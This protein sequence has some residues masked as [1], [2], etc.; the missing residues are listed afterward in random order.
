MPHC[1][2]LIL[3]SAYVFIKSLQV[4]MH[5]MLLIWCI[6]SIFQSEDKKFYVVLEK[7]SLLTFPF[8][9]LKLNRLKEC[10]VCVVFF[11]RK[12][13]CE[14]SMQMACNCISCIVTIW[15]SLLFHSNALRFNHPRL[16]FAG[17][18]CVYSGL[19]QWL[20]SLPLA[21]CTSSI[22]A[23]PYVLYKSKQ[24]NHKH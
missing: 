11:S 4:S 3:C 19:A 17:K 24:K 20:E 6:W 15:V 18:T 2:N 21:S 14:S 12:I 7:E 9:L 10:Q 22:I 1:D 16:A 8:H 13:E 5:H 23:T